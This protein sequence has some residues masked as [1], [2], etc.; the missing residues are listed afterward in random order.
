[1]AFENSLKT[2]NW[3]LKIFTLVRYFKRL[4]SVQKYLKNILK[5]LDFLKISIIIIL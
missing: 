4:F 2:S 5:R 3:C 1:M